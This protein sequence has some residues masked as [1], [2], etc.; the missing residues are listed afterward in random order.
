MS[1]HYQGKPQ[2]SCPRQHKL[3]VWIIP[4]LLRASKR[5]PKEQA[6]SAMEY[7]DEVL[8]YTESREGGDLKNS[9]HDM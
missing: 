4:L 7:A 1:V 3:L 6:Y 8:G 5:V 2:G 9:S